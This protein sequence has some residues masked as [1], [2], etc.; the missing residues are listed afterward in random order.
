MA[1]PCG[2]YTQTPASDVIPIRSQRRQSPLRTSC[3]TPR[4]AMHC[5]YNSYTNDISP[6][7]EYRVSQSYGRRYSRCASVDVESA[8]AATRLAKLRESEAASGSACV[9]PIKHVHNVAQGWLLSVLVCFFFLSFFLSMVPS[10]LLSYVS[11]RREESLFSRKPLFSALVLPF[12]F[13][14]KSFH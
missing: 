8:P 7:S 6:Y 5:P 13:L 9:C 2:L 3:L 12:F 4:A 10:P 14:F 1:R 11:V